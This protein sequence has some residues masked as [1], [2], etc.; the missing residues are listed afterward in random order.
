MQINLNMPEARGL[1]VGP[2][3]VRGSFR[4]AERLAAWWRVLR[5]ANG[6]GGSS[7]YRSAECGGGWKAG[8][9]SQEPAGYPRVRGISR[10]ELSRV[11]APLPWAR[12]GP[13]RRG[14]RS[15]LPPIATGG[16]WGRPRAPARGHTAIGAYR[17]PPW[18]SANAVR[19]APAHVPSA[20]VVRAAPQSGVLGYAS[21]ARA[22]HA[23]LTQP[24]RWPATRTS[25]SVPGARQDAPRV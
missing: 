6:G 20:C 7:W 19:A 5:R 22:S 25:Q 2:P 23:G 4:V 11:C 9:G 8:C 1:E 16:A 18:L 10:W 14:C 15:G 17:A 21:H 3:G 12:D 13:E 24:R